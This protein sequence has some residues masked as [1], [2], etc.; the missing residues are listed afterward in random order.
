MKEDEAIDPRKIG[1]YIGKVE[2]IADDDTGQ[3]KGNGSNIYPVGTK[4]YK[5]NNQSSDSAI[6]VEIGN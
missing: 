3:Y 1:K 5:L 6:A 2:S 4:Y